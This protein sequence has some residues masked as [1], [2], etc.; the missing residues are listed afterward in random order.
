MGNLLGQSV[1]KGRMAGRNVD[2][3]IS[4]PKQYTTVFILL[5]VLA[6]SA[7]AALAAPELTCEELEAKV[8]ELTR[9]VEALERRPVSPPPKA[10]ARASAPAPAAPNPNVQQEAR[11]LYF[12]IDELVANGEIDVARQTLTSYNEKYAGTPD[13]RWFGS[14]NREFAV[15]G[16]PAPD[17]WAIEKWFRGEGDLQ[18]DGDRTTLVVFWEVWCPHCK[19]EV[20]ELQKRYESYGSKGLQ[21][22]ALTKVS[23]TAT[24]EAVQSFISEQGVTYPVAKETGALSEYFSVK[25]IPAAAIVKDGK[26]VWRGHPTRITDAMLAKWL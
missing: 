6:G 20:P 22:L 7:S 24:E 18:L 15:I 5:V 9:R 14:L 26:I 11:A 16:K 12:K 3:E 25:G 23:K 2:Q 19:R 21:V 1:R 17:E 10:P 13:I 8:A 4:M